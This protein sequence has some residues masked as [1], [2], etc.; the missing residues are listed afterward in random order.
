MSFGTTEL[1]IWYQ[2][3]GVDTVFRNL[4]AQYLAAAGDEGADVLYPGSSPYV[5]SVGGT[6][7]TGGTNQRYAGTPGPYQEVGWSGSGG[8]ISFFNPPPAYQIGWSSFAKRSVPDVSYNAGSFVSVY[9]TDPYTLESGWVAVGG[10]SAATPQW[11]AIIAR[12]NASG[13]DLKYKRTINEE[14]YNISRK[15][16]KSLFYDI[17]QGTNGYKANSVNF[18][19]LPTSS[20]ISSSSLIYVWYYRSKAF[21]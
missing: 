5:L 8:G 16:F 4:S 1:S 3:N 13:L 18:R 17:K 10:T 9:H 15:S 2:P 7:L 14:I 19:F 21:G 11:A 6:T 12:R 20:S